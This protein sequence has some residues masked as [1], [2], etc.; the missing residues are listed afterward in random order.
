MDREFDEL[1]KVFNDSI[2][3]GTIEDDWLHSSTTKD[4]QRPYCV[5][6]SPTITMQNTVGKLLEKNNKSFASY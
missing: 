4:R 5:A 3:S 1:V 6:S 2:K